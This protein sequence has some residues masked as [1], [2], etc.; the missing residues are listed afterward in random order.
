MNLK[1]FTNQRSYNIHEN[2]PL[3]FSG[4]PRIGRRYR[5][6]PTRATGTPSTLAVGGEEGA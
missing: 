6:A 3:S 1:Y 5:C 4:P 2:D